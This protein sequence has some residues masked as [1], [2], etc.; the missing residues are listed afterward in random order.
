VDYGIF[1]D[2]TEIKKR[3]SVFLKEL[4]DS[5]KAEGQDRIY[6]HGEKEAEM[7]GIR[8]NG[9]IPVNEKTFQEF[10]E[11]AAAQGVGNVE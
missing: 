10:R 1:G 6:T 9:S 7:I 5:R 3:I 4:R 2:K 11:I 8:K